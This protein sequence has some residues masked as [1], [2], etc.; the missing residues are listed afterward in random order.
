MK[1]RTALTMLVAIPALAAHAAFE[2][3]ARDQLA[4]IERAATRLALHRPRA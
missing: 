4:E 3:W 1:T 2:A